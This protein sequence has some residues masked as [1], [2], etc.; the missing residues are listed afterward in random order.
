MASVFHI[1]EEEAARDFGA[2]MRRVRASDLVVVDC[3]DGT[4]ALIRVRIPGMEP[5]RRTLADA[6]RILRARQAIQPLAVAGPE[7]AE[8]LAAVHDRYN[9]P[10]DDSKWV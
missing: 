4:E 9:A 1:T 2:L 8:D 7:F 10:M 6:Q 3:E 5:E